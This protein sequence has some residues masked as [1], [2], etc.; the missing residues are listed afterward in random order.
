MAEL[1]ERSVVGPEDQLFRA[2]KPGLQ[3][4]GMP[5]ERQDEHKGEDD[6]GEAGADSPGSIQRGVL[7]HFMSSFSNDPCPPLAVD[8]SPEG[9]P[10]GPADH[11]DDF[12]SGVPRLKVPQG[13]GGLLQRVGP[14][15][16]GRDPSVLH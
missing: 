8:S 11:H 3:Q 6:E 13:L 15:D 5:C 16:H 4:V 12:A 2:E 10:S 9:I 14:V 7:L 1:Q